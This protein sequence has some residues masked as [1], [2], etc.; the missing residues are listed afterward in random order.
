VGKSEGAHVIILYGYALVF[1]LG[2]IMGSL[3]VATT[4]MF[5]ERDRDPEP[6]PAPES[7]MVFQSYQRWLAK[8]AEV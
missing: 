7:G 5:G 8:Q 4:I 2:F 3:M 6:I 1:A